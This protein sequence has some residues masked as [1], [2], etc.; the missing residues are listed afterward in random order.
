MRVDITV[1][2]R[3]PAHATSMGRVLLA[4]LPVEQRAKW[5][6]RGELQPLTTRTVTDA[7]RLATLA[8]QAER[9]GFALV[10]QELEQGLLSIAVPV[11]GPGGRVIAVVNVS[12]HVGRTSLE[13][14]PRLVLPELREA[15]RRISEDAALVFDL[16]PPPLAR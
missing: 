6:R 8:E 12:L 14:A 7:D 11:R 3:F 2:T 10:D 9:E 4:G 5:L 16:Q 15:A 1:G 13:E